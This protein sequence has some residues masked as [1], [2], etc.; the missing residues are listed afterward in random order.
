MTGQPNP[1][2]R[3]GP[4]LRSEFADDPDMKE[5]LT[6]FIQ[7]MPERVGQLRQFWD[8]RQLENL[9][10]QAHQL[11]GAGGGYGYPSISETAGK[12]ENSLA[13]ALGG[14][15]DEQLTRIKT[16]LDELVDLCQRV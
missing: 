6:M 7:E 14:A 8:S 11:K 9:K 1:N 4:E 10:R 2:S 15:T 3:P 12:L 5:I 16:Q 13:T